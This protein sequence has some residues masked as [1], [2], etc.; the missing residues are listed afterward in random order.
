M[1]MKTEI[2]I[3]EIEREYI[4]ANGDDD[5]MIKIKNTIYTQLPLNEKRMILLYAEL[6]SY[7]KVA[8]FFE[9]SPATICK[10][11]NSIKNKIKEALCYI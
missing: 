1:E 9:C 3:E 4:P 11:I 6:G 5:E 8:E 2:E 10:C 7:R